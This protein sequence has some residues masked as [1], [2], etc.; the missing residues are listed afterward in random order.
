[1]GGITVQSAA[2]NGAHVQQII[3]KLPESLLEDQRRV[4]SDF[5]Q[6]NADI[7]SSEFDLGRVDLVKHEIDT[8]DNR[9]FKQQLRRHPMGHLEI[10]DDHVEKML[11]H[12]II[13]PTSS[14]WASNIVLV[15]KSNGELRFCIDYRQL[16]NLTLK[17]SYPLP[18]ID[19]CMDALGGARY[20]STLDL[21]SGYWQV[22]M[23]EASAQKAA[24]VTRKG[25]WKFNV[26][27]FGLSNAPAISQRLMDLVLAGLT[28]QICLAFLDDVI[29]MSATFEQHVERLTLVFDR[30][31]KANLKLHPGKCKLFQEKVK[32]LGSIVSGEGISPDPE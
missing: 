23:D 31:R 12:G 17:D 4:S 32:F 27:P 2:V 7:F 30:I 14:Q 24:F 22:A 28:W 16:N 15:R 25:V 18:R 8:G 20:F 9:P 5:I 19:S 1:V 6:R 13:S 3:D 29:V 11:A 26:L 10:I 21:R